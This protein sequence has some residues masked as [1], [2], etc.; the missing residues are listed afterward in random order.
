M[1]E[2][3]ILTGATK[4]YTAPR[5]DVLAWEVRTPYNVWTEG[6]KRKV[7]NKPYRVAASAKRALSFAMRKYQMC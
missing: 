4:E 2:I 3:D 5:F 7:E 6:G 1:K